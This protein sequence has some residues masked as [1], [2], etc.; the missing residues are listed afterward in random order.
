MLNIL[1]QIPI[2]DAPYLTLDTYLQLQI[3]F[4]PAEFS[5]IQLLP[6]PS[7]QDVHPSSSVAISLPAFSF[8]HLATILAIQWGS[9][10]LSQE[11]E[12]NCIQPAS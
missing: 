8:R 10:C 1:Y 12:A 9:W 6:E 5:Y 4:F 3:R 11:E 2:F 7:F